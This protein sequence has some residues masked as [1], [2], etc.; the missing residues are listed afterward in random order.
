MS[1]IINVTDATFEREVLAEKG[2]VLVDFG[3]AWCP[4][5]RALEPILESLAKER[6]GTLKV[7]K[8]DT[9]ESPGVAQRLSIRATPTLVVFHDGQK[10]AVQVGAVPKERLIALIDRTSDVTSAGR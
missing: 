5:C 9:E 7:V 10:R 4:P 3:A 8:I 1:R 6:E 2:T